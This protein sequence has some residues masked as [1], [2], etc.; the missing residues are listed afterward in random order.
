MKPAAQALAAEPCQA[1][2]PDSPAVT[3]PE[4]ETLLVGLPDWRIVAEDTDRLTAGFTFRNFADALAFAV[5]VGALAEAADHH[6]LLV[7]E[8]GP[9]AGL[10]VDARH[11][12][13]APQRL[14]PGRTDIPTA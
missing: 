7:V 11:R 10:L 5:R 13:L 6:P 9:S 2:R 4:A 14:H 3:R 1:C 12:R 8:W